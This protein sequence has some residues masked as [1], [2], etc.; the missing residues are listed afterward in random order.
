MNILFLVHVEE[1]FRDFFPDKMYVN[2]LIRAMNIYDRVIIL[3]SEVDAPS[4][5]HELTAGYCCFDKWTWGWGYEPDMFDDEENEW[6]ISTG[7][8][9][10]WTWVPPEIRDA[11]AWNQHEI[12][13]GGGY[14]TECLQDWLDVLNHVGIVHRLVDGYVYG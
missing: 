1:M 5:I 14:R 3:D 8:P 2:R 12:L 4:I 6:I 7:S 10:E 11:E 13:V 9:H